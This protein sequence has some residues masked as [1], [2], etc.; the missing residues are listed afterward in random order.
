MELLTDAHDLPGD[1]AKIPGDA[2]IN[3]AVWAALQ[4]IS[5][6]TV[7]RQR[8]LSES[9]RG[10][11]QAKPGDMPRADAVVGNSPVWTMDTY[12]AWEASRPGKG[13]GAGRPKGSGKGRARRT[14]RLPIRCPHCH[15][16][17][18]ARQLA[19]ASTE[20]PIGLPS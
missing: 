8:T 11:P 4:G 16:R 7:Y 9:R 10:T 20:A 6:G 1:W 12:R 19:D 13:A 15:E 5:V 17:I 2:Y 14:A 3:S 18:T